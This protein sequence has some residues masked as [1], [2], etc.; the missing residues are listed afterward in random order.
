[1]KRCYKEATMTGD[2][3]KRAPTV[4][5]ADR[6]HMAEVYLQ[7]GLLAWSWAELRLIRARNYWIATVTAAG[8][9]HSR[10][11]WAV[12]LDNALFFSTGPSRIRKHLDHSAAVS[13]NLESGDECLILEGTAEL[14]T[15]RDTLVRVA[16]AYLAKYTWSMETTPG[17]FFRVDPKMAFAWISDG[18]GEDRGVIFSA[19]ATRFRF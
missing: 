19:T 13:V 6:P 11:V 12:W 15:N 3:T 2:S 10:P 16:A 4:P 7:G 8:R 18:T 14:E 17:T 5:Q 9:P 1:M